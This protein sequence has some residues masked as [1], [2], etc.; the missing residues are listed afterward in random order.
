MLA[1]YYSSSQYMVSVRLRSIFCRR[2]VRLQACV[3][4]FIVAD[5]SELCNKRGFY[6][7]VR[8]GQWERLCRVYTRYG[9]RGRRFLHD[10]SHIR[11][12]LHHLLSWPLQKPHHQTLAVSIWDR[13]STTV[14]P[15]VIQVCVS[16]LH[17][18]QSGEI[19]RQNACPY[20]TCLN[21]MAYWGLR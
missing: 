15:W 1:V 10:S 13:V 11:H 18:L 12:A 17:C 16:W 2:S 3:S 8:L 4:V 14:E 20:E 7:P 9:G 19:A 6:E 21:L 5:R